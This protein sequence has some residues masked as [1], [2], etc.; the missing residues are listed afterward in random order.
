MPALQT[1]VLAAR[2]QP[3]RIGLDC[4]IRVR[5]DYRSQYASSEVDEAA[6]F[7]FFGNQ[8]NV[9]FV[10]RYSC[11]FRAFSQIAVYKHQRFFT[12]SHD[13]VCFGSLYHI[14]IW[15]V[16]VFLARSP[17]KEHE[18]DHHVESSE[19]LTVHSANSMGW[20]GSVLG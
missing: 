3:T 10:N 8:D 17:E 18:N 1:V 6:V 16:H 2:N 13:F 19:V 5:L 15:N 12:E 9:I 4:H 7:G 11:C 14:A 20:G